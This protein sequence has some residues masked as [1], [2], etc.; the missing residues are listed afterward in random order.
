M[1]ERGV[2]QLANV[3]KMYKIF[4]SRL[5]HFLV[6][7]GL[8]R[9]MPWREIRPHEFWALRNIDFE[10]KAGRRL[11]IIGRN[12]AGKST[13]LKLITGNLAPSEG[14]VTVEGQVQA[15]LEAGSGF[16][17]EFTGYENVNAALTYQGLSRAEIARATEDIA[18]FTELGDFLKQPYKT[19]STGMMARLVF[20]VATAV[21]PNILIIDEILGAGDAYFFAKSLDRMK[22]LVLESGASVL[23]VSHSVGHI[24]QF[25]DEA[26]WI[27]RGRIMKRG[28]SVEVVNAYE[29]FIRTLD[30]RRLRGKNIKLRSKTVPS[31]LL[32]NYGDTISFTFSAEGAAG[33]SADISDVQLLRN[34][35]VE[36]EV[37]VGGVQDSTTAFS[38]FILLDNSQWSE[39]TASGDEHFRSL[40]VSGPAN[41]SATGHGVFYMYGLATDSTYQ[42]RIRYRHDASSRLAISVVKNGEVL[43]NQHYLPES[44]SD[45]NES[46]LPVVLAP[47]ESSALAEKTTGETDV[48]ASEPAVSSGNGS[49][50]ESAAGTAVPA[51]RWPSEGSIT[52]ERM[53]T[54]DEAGRELVVVT[55]GTSMTICVSLLAHRDGQ[56]DCVPAVTLQRLDGVLI[57]NFVGRAIPLKLT[58]GE[59]KTARVTIPRVLFGDG[60]YRL[61]GSIF[62]KIVSESTRYDLIAHGC[63]FKVTGN[64]SLV[65]GF[66]VQHPTTEWVIS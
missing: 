41:G 45:W 7:L 21:K 34:G 61:S 42:L 40:T 47:R 63:E 56:F 4:S 2:I 11:G 37:K 52:I 60:E 1:S 22:K 48:A 18:D 12:G 43:Y 55:P 5:D 62:E 14:V 10:L 59:R 65:S 36:D 58:R 13:L 30:E 20:A 26:I 35:Q 66:V 51:V 50:A 19:Y 15:L 39:P 8:S 32:D 24:L 28:R 64:D 16:H 3:G 49:G 53:S 44:A 33:A 17:P 29:G 38:A 57:S 23:L 6:A 25:C 54:H 31:F 46:E 27:E 9:L